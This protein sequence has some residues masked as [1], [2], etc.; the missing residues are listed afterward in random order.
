MFGTLGMH[1]S[2]LPQ[3][4]SHLRDTELTFMK[5]N[6]KI[7][8][9]NTSVYVMEQQFNM[10]VYTALGNRG[11]TVKLH[12]EYV[13]ISGEQINSVYWKGTKLKINF[14]E[15]NEFDIQKG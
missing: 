13:T 2:Y 14:L 9:G 3:G 7:K 11:F 12:K 10:T 15:G 5:N 8:Q 6:N 4:N 1:S